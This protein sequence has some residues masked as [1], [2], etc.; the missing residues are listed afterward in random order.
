MLMRPWLIAATIVAAGC[1]GRASERLP[2]SDEPTASALKVERDLLLPGSTGRFDYQSLDPANRTLWIAHLGDSSVLAVDLATGRVSE[3]PDVGGVHGV[4]A[5]PSRGVVYATATS[6]NEIVSIDPTK[7]SIT[8]RAPAGRFPDGLAYDAD[9]ELLLVTN[10][11]DGAITVHD[12]T[13]LALVRTV[14]L[15]DE[16][17]NVAYDPTSQLGYATTL[18][19]GEL[20]SFRPDTGEVVERLALQGC[21]GAHGLML[22]SAGQRAFVACE[23]NAK[24]LTVDLSTESVTAIFK[25]GDNPDVF[26]FD[27]AN[28][29]LMLAAESGEVEWFNTTPALPESLGRTHID[30]GAH[31]VAV[32]PSTK[33]WFFPLADVDG[34]PALRIATL[35]E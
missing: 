30:G 29:R 10:K 17:G 15:G 19:P 9:H 7:L 13:T 31:S 5:V 25:V 23:G 27:P 35:A 14:E 8:Q 18:P 2:T 26:A 11:L 32:D 6:T 4:L 16:T 3:I 12:P 21:E 34:H 22:D 28:Q 24:M 1:G 33:Q 20:V